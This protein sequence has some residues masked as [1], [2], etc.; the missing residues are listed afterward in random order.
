[1]TLLA[2][3]RTAEE[4]QSAAK[5]RGNIDVELLAAAIAELSKSLEHRLHGIEQKLNSIETTTRQLR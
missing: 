2:A 1:M 3:R 5:A 4:A